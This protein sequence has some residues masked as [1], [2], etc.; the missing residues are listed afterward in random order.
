MSKTHHH[1][2][3]SGSSS[4]NF[5]SSGDQKRFVHTYIKG[6]NMLS[7]HCI[8]FTHEHL[9][10]RMR[11]PWS[12]THPVD[13]PS[14]FCKS[15]LSDVPEFPITGSKKADLCKMASDAKTTNEVMSLCIFCTLKLAFK[16]MTFILFYR[17]HANGKTEQLLFICSGSVRC[18][19]RCGSFPSD[20]GKSFR[21]MWQFNGIVHG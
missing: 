6:F 20:R 3:H 14:S 18:Q 11:S 10:I 15:S 8:H 12:A 1:N 19:W 13:V 7:L 2:I 9:W 4:G 21:K 17:D 16:T 5:K